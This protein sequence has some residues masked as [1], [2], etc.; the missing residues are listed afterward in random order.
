LKVTRGYR[1]P[2]DFALS[3]RKVQGGFEFSEGTTANSSKWVFDV[4][5]KKLKAEVFL[6]VEKIKFKFGCLPCPLIESSKD[7]F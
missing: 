1:K 2:N 6:Y 5:I 3:K 7:F 4:E